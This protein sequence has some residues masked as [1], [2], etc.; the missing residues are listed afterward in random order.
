MNPYSKD[1]FIVFHS[2]KEYPLIEAYFYSTDPGL[3]LHHEAEIWALGISAF[4]T[5]SNSRAKVHTKQAV[6]T[7][8]EKR[9]LNHT[10]PFFVQLLSILN[11]SSLLL[12]IHQFKKLV[13]EA[14][15]FTAWFLASCRQY[16]IISFACVYYIL[17]LFQ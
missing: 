5:S 11:S 13:F 6:I 17:L 10:D 7:A 2:N 14:S 4:P 16:G 3:R 1:E 12:F 9:N 8:Q 15:F